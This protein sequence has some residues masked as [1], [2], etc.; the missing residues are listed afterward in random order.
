MINVCAYRDGTTIMLEQFE[1]E[2]EAYAFM[3][4]GCIIAYAD[5]TD[6]GEEIYVE[7]DEMFISNEEVPFAEIHFGE[8]DD[9]LPY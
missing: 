6:N 3:Q 2:E 9:F 5:E 4:R 8:L 7:P 1:T